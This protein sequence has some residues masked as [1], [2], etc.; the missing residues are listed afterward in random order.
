MDCKKCLECQNCFTAQGKCAE[1]QNC[2]TA[3]SGRTEWIYF[4]YIITQACNQHCAY[5]WNIQEPKHLTLEQMKKGYQRVKEAFPDR[6]IGIGFFGGEPLLEFDTM[7][8][9][10]KDMEDEG[11]TGY[12]MTTNLT[13]ITEEVLEWIDK[14]NVD[15]VLS[16]DGPKA[17]NI[18]RGN[19]EKIEPWIPR[20]IDLQNKRGKRY[21][22]RMTMAP[23]I[24]QY[25]PDFLEWAIKVGFISIVAEITEGNHEK[26][27][28]TLLRLAMEKALHIYADYLCSGYWVDFKIARDAVAKFGNQ[29]YTCGNSP[30]NLSC[31]ADG[32][33]Y[34]CHRFATNQ[35]AD[36]SIIY[37]DIE[38]GIDVK[39]MQERADSID[40][41]KISS[42]YFD[43]STCPAK[44]MCSGGCFAANY[45]ENGDL[46]KP[47]KAY[48][49]GKRIPAEILK[50][51][52]NDP[53]TSN[54]IRNGFSPEI[55]DALIFRK[56]MR[57]IATPLENL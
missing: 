32:K 34:P 49:L 31:G 15:L 26:Y 52:K 12:S 51:A 56:V 18:L 3:Q 16:L 57:G 43:C 45:E 20:L 33:F 50:E 10:T 13:L 53:I 28:E 14:Y 30:Y 37:G 23:Q 22:A 9:F 5:C 1:C 55:R 42:P 40:L 36:E 29:K 7:K 47:T 4:N 41:K 39:K 27:D 46:L 21:T 54:W 6:G 8:Q 35:F 19:W 24:V 25:L 2:F 48:C 38:T 44:D 17:H 11:I